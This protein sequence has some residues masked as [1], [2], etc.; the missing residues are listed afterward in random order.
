MLHIISNPNAIEPCT[1]HL[2]DKDEI[3]FIGDGVYGLKGAKLDSRFPVYA[4]VT[5][6]AARGITATSN[7]MPASMTQF[8]CLAVQHTSSVT[9]T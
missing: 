4:L 6:L 7:V 8:V 1:R 2:S 9:W 5:D 3:V